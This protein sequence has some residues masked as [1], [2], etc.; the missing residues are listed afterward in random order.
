M[1]ILDVISGCVCESVSKKEMKW[2]SEGA[3]ESF[4]LEIM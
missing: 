4:I 1:L 2:P 3:A